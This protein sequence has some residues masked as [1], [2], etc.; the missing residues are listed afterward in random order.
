VYALSKFDQERLCLIMGR[1]YGIPTAALRFFNTYGPRQALRNPYTGVLAIF[2]SC[3]LRGKPPLV[4]EDGLQQRDFVHVRDVARA[5]RLALA[6]PEEQLTREGEPVF[7]VGSGEPRTILDVAQRLC[8]VLSRDIPPRINGTYRMGDIRHCFADIGKAERV[9][10][11]RPRVPFEQ[12]LRDL[13]RWLEGQDSD[14]ASPEGAGF[15]V[16]LRE[17]AERGLSIAVQPEHGRSHEGDS[18][19]AAA[20]AR[21]QA[22]QMAADEAVH[23]DRDRVL[24]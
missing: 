18:T 7:N 22:R 8:A 12:G 1:A 24:P 15:D 20:P 23:A 5:C 9:L 13:A 11:Y 2:A 10:D 3:L 19:P 14:V 17:L 21:R 16:A 6:A 4:Y